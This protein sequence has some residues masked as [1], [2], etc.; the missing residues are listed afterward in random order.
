MKKTMNTSYKTTN[1][2]SLPTLKNTTKMSKHISPFLILL[3]VLIATPIWAQVPDPG[4]DGGSLNASISGSSSVTVNSTYRYN[5]TASNGTHHSST[6]SV[7]GGTITSQATGYVYVK[8]TSVGTNR[9]VRVI[10]NVGSSNI[11]KTKYV[12][13]NNV[14]PPSTPSTPTVSPNTCGNK[15][16][17]R[18]TPSDGSTWYW[19]TSP[20]GTSTSDYSPSKTVTSSQTVY[21]RAKKSGL[22][23]SGSSSKS[24]TVNH[25][26]ATPPAPSITM[27]CGSSVVPKTGVS[28]ATVYWQTSSG[29]TSTG[30][31]ASSKTLT[32]SGTLYLR[33]R[34]SAGCWSSTRTVSV[35]VNAVPGLPPSPTISSNMCGDR[36][37]YLPTGSGVN[38]YWQTSPGQ[39]SVADNAANKVLST[40]ETLYIQGKGTNGCWGPTRTVNVVVK[41]IPDAPMLS[42]SS[43]N[44]GDKVVSLPTIPN[45]V[46]YYWQTVNGGTDETDTAPSKTLTST[47]TLYAR[48]VSNEGCWSTATSIAAVTV[49]QPP[50]APATPSQVSLPD[51]TIVTKGSAP[52][53]ET[54]Y[55]QSSA[56]GE[57]Q[58]NADT[59]YPAYESTT[60]YLRSKINAG[61]WGPAITIPVTVVHDPFITGVSSTVVLTEGLTSTS[62]V[63]DLIVADKAKRST[64]MDGLGRTI[65]SVGWRVSP[66]QKDMVS[67]VNYDHRGR[68]QKSYLSY[69]STDTTGLYRENAIGGTNEQYQFYQNAANVAHDT[70]PFAE[71]RYEPS[72]MGRVLEQGAVGSN[73]SL[74]SGKTT[75]VDFRVN[76]SAD[77]NIYKWTVTG[78]LPATNGTYA[79]GDL[80]ISET[81]DAENH[82]VMVYTDKV[83]KTILKRMDYSP[84]DKYTYY[85]YNDKN[86]LAYLIPPKEAADITG[87]TTVNQA[88]ADTRLYHYTYDHRGRVKTKETPDA[89]EV[90]YVYDQFDRVVLT[91]D[92]NQ[93]AKATPEW[94]FV[95]YD[96]LNRVVRTGTY[97]TS[98]STSTLET[99]AAANGHATVQA[100]ST[101]DLSTC[102]PS[103]ATD[104]SETYYDR[105]LSGSLTTTYDTSFDPDLGTNAPI[106]DYN[107]HGKRTR[108][109]TN[110]LDTT[111]WLETVSFFDEYGRTIQVHSQNHKNGTDIV[112]LAYDFAGRLLKTV[113][114]YENPVA[115]DMKVI[116]SMTYDHAGRLLTLNHKVNDAAPVTLAAYE[117]NELG[118]VIKK[119]QRKASPID[120][121]EGQSGVTYGE[122]YSLDTLGANRLIVASDQIVLLPGFHAKGSDGDVTM[123]IDPVEEG[124]IPSGEVAQ[125]IDYAYNIRG[126]LNAINDASLTLGDDPVQD[127][128]GMEL[129]Y[130]DASTGHEQYTGLIGEVKWQGYT[131][132][133]VKSYRYT[134]DELN[135]LET[136][137]Y[138]IDGSYT[139]N[140]Y[141]VTNVGYD[142]NGN[143]TGLE[144]N[145]L[146]DGT[147]EQVDDLSFTYTA[148]QLTDVDDIVNKELGFNDRAETTNEYTYD[149]NGNMT[150]DLNKEMTSI[151]Y[152]HL[153]LAEEVQFSDGRK[154]KYGYTAGG[155][156]LWQE[157]YEASSSAPNKTRDFLGGQ[158]FENDTLVS[159]QT[160]EGRLVASSD[161]LDYQYDLKDHQ[162]NT[163]LTF[164]TMPKNYTI[165]ET[166]ETGEDNGFEDL[167]RHTNANA[168][169][170]EN[171]NE[172]ERLQ[173]DETGAMIF[174]S[175]NKGD[176]IDLSVNAN[177]EAA[178]SGNAFLGTA[179]S[180]L[181]STYNSAIAGGEAG[182][183]VENEFSDALGGA[184]LAGKSGSSTA[185]RA[186][187]NYIFFDS[188]MNYITAG[189]EQVSTAALGI[190]VHET[191]SINDIIAG[192][193]GYLLTYLSNENQDSVSMHFDDFTVYHGKT[194]VVQANDYYPFGL[195]SSSYQRTASL[196]N[197]YLY[198]EGSRLEEE[199]EWYNTAFRKY[200][201]SIGRFT[202]V[203]PLASSMASINSYHYGYNNPV[204]FS[205]ALGLMPD[206]GGN[207]NPT[208]YAD[209]SGQ[210]SGGGSGLGRWL[211]Q[212]QQGTFQ[213]WGIHGAGDHING[214]PY[215]QGS[216][217]YLEH[218][219]GAYDLARAGSQDALDQIGAIQVAANGEWADNV[220]VYE[221]YTV[222]YVEGYGDAIADFTGTTISF[223]NIFKGFTDNVKFN[224][225]PWQDRDWDF[226]EGGLPQL[227]SGSVNGSGS[228]TRAKWTETYV[229]L[230]IG[231]QT[232]RVSNILD[233]AKELASG[234]DKWWSG[235]G[236]TSS[237]TGKSWQVIEIRGD[238]LF[239]DT[240]QLSTF[241]VDSILTN[242][243]HGGDS[244][245]TINPNPNWYP[246]R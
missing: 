223:G 209:N 221:N 163:R 10:A 181:F 23:S 20:S 105:Y 70:Q 157:F 25:N 79:N 129:L 125:E 241:K 127:L 9:W 189:F 48:A 92:A 167:H 68:V 164:S 99:A 153:N 4:G 26:P 147:V 152:N 188:D 75:K 108:T 117:Y 186:F 170:T 62:A 135:Q 159:V 31:A 104:L 191:L 128:F 24:V 76:S 208:P 201:A 202:A 103:G 111:T 139:Q 216:A 246:E 93:R 168:N 73:W 210:G 33:A 29:G 15:T 182:S 123:W 41:A 185:P 18:G 138:G 192:E 80:M 118:Q 64:Y 91:Q 154:V 133:A 235:W 82:L 36:T 162:G 60:L 109:R 40:S 218:Q 71:T 199:T 5:V 115:G 49:N 233:R 137:S 148:N 204:N 122:S 145:G 142:L 19:Q 27:N 171:G 84:S 69:A 72:P 227:T 150:K 95:K 67:A 206:G 220:T 37:V 213:Q 126:W 102:Y 217:A 11:T 232:A 165:T 194:N 94:S 47:Q 226:Q 244:T 177:Y 140:T 81:R 228:S 42:V 231:Y 169:T 2:I 161:G 134:Y 136:A 30:D 219:A 28:G 211:G 88:Y 55:W 234:I 156:L 225:H 124:Q 52:A 180:A 38:Y 195:S 173:S 78:G 61:C 193:E 166:F 155:T 74:T 121:Y 203:D 101:Y 119:E 107:V 13:V 238:T 215:S 243:S 198:N 77:G 236:S 172:V 16:A 224:K 143:I 229:D 120:Y 56:A 96:R 114:F 90:Q 146:N 196:F 205:D 112:T 132:N 239:Y 174:I 12:T 98:S 87:G 110:V 50:L 43:N 237:Y 39:S 197:A 176:T 44:C 113:T 83:G 6:Y 1:Q 242:V 66:N 230:V 149:V 214:N 14:P 245:I 178:P 97:A 158:V 7:S 86:Q 190:G 222:K 85:V 45:G 141:G 89:G 151:A 57:D 212:R 184:N 100:D 131:D 144:R 53:G 106:P 207:G 63:D 17:N 22:W 58:T 8:W 32:S 240:E 51:Q 46:T 175:M 183:A 35:T 3:F 116:K 187:L 179:F 21:L 130:Q 200:D 59:D 34:T 65:Q 54:W 160:E